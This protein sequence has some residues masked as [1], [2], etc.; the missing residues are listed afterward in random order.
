MNAFVKIIRTQT[1]R[2]RRTRWWRR[3]WWWWRRRRIGHVDCKIE[4]KVRLGG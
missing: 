3:W 2:G 1:I 4:E